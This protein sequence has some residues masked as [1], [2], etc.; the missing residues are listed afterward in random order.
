MKR[1]RRELNNKNIASRCTIYQENLPKDIQISE[2]VEFCRRAG[3]QQQQN[4]GEPK[5]KLYKDNNGEQK[6]DAIVTYLQSESV[7]IALDILDGDT[8][9]ENYPVKITRAVFDT[10]RPR[11][12]N[13]TGMKMTQTIQQRA[14]L[15][16]LSWDE[17][18]DTRSIGQ[19]AIVILNAYVLQEFEESEKSYDKLYEELTKKMQQFCQENAG[20]VHRIKVFPKNKLGAILVRFKT[21][22]AAQIAVENLSDIQF[23]GRKLQIQYLDRDIIQYI[24]QHSLEETEEQ[25][26]Q[27]FGDWIDTL[28]V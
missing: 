1:I 8:I 4:T 17:S 26:L 25:R 6:G 13:N 14:Q 24:N 3:Q 27:S 10:K 2:V 9:R 16:A 28:D 12:I 7:D 18:E 23:C 11:T 20:P 19:K 22:G 5:V 15:Q 21:T